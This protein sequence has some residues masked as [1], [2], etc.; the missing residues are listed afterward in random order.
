MAGQPKKRAV[1]AELSRRAAADEL[2]SILDYAI[3]WVESGGSLTSLAADLNDKL[4]VGEIGRDL[5][6]RVVYDSDETGEAEARLAN[7]RGA[8]AHAIAES[9]TVIADSSEDAKLKVQSRQWLAARWNRAEYGENRGPNVAISFGDG[10]LNALR[11]MAPAAAA[12]ATVA[13]DVRI[14]APHNSPHADVIE[15]EDEA[16]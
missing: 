7:A 6:R 8:G 16:N 4:G 11:G 14:A 5:V 1:A 3:A 13:E 2:P 15:M 10:F 12:I 9:T